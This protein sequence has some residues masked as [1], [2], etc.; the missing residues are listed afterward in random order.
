ML[1]GHIHTELRLLG[2]ARHGNVGGVAGLCGQNADVGQALLDHID[3][4]SVFRRAAA[5]FGVRVL[6]GEAGHHGALE[7]DAVAVRHHHRDQRLDVLRQPDRQG[8]ELGAG[9]QDR[10]DMA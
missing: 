10:F 8:I 3:H 9:V 4:I 7:G 1:A 5:Q 6:L 2:Q